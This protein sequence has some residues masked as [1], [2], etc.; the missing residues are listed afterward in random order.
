VNVDSRDANAATAWSGALART[1]VERMKNDPYL[2]V[3]L[4]D[5]A[6]SSVPTGRS[7]KII[8]F[9]AL[10][11]LAFF[12]F[13]LVAFGAQRLEE[14][15]DVPGALRRRGVRVLGAVR[16]SRRRN[17]RDGLRA[18][19]GILLS[20]GHEDGRVVVTAMNDPAIA[21]L[22]VGLLDREEELIVVEELRGAGVVSGIRAIV[23][24]S[25]DE[26]CLRGSSGDLVGCVLAVDERL[27]SVTEIVASVELMQQAGVPF[28]GV[29]LIR[30]SHMA[31][32]AA[33][34]QLPSRESDSILDGKPGVRA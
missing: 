3:Q 5:P 30:G 4:L 15:R 33:G 11:A 10:F 19:I 31:H 21:Q 24:P 12:A 23:G 27:W 34:T 17:G 13:V 29:I 16:A 22:L 1:L 9:A 18:V 7:V 8:T 6:E 28:R 25:V 14:A 32:E 26:L 2:G 20:D